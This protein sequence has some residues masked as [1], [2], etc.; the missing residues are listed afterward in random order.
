[1]ASE[2]DDESCDYIPEALQILNTVK[3]FVFTDRPEYLHPHK[4]LTA[5]MIHAP[6][7]TAKQEIAKDIVDNTDD[8]DPVKGLTLLTEYWWRTLLVP[9]NILHFILK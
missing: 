6:S 1:M 2:S 9:C 7:D 4:V 3:D 8:N 5:L